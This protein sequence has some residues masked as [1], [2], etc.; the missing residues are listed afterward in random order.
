MTDVET[1]GGI[2][3]WQKIVIGA[4]LVYLVIGVCVAGLSY[5]NDVREY[6]FNNRHRSD[7]YKGLTEEPRIG[8]YVPFVFGWPYYAILLLIFK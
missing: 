7:F 8:S 4:E 1:L 3:M 5:Y 6:N 2:M